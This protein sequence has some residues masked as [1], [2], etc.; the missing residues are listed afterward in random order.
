LTE[1]NK[2]GYISVVYKSHDGRAMY[3]VMFSSKII[4]KSDMMKILTKIRKILG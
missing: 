2:D 3:P 1:P 4:S